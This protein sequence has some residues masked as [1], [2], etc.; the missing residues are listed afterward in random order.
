MLRVRR[1]A[2]SPIGSTDDRPGRKGRMGMWQ[3]LL[4]RF[5]P[6]MD[7]DVSALDQRDGVGSTTLSTPQGST[8]EAATVVPAPS[9]QA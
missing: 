9:S 8:T 6:L 2:Q 5:V 7:G 1:T 3:L 4:D